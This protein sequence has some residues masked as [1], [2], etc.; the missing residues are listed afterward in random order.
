MTTTRRRMNSALEMG[1]GIGALAAGAVMSKKSNVQISPED[2]DFF[3][4]IE[5]LDYTSVGSDIQLIGEIESDILNDIVAFYKRK[6]K[7]N[8]IIML[9]ILDDDAEGTSGLAFCSDKLL[10]WEDDWENLQMIY[11]S[12]IKEVTFSEDCIFID[13]KPDGNTTVYLGA[14]AEDEK[15]PRYMY[16]FIMD[17]LDFYNQTQENEP[18]VEVVDDVDTEEL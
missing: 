13:S 4:F 11:Y 2:K 12:E 9:D 6:V 17:I 15:Y 5:S 14:Y 10:Y 7:K 8:D 3:E 16:N 18:Q 1:L